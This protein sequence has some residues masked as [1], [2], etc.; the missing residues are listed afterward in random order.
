MGT[1]FN[2]TWQLRNEIFLRD[3]RNLYFKG[4]L[5]WSFFLFYGNI[6]LRSGEMKGDSVGI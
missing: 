1:K 3:K 4:I 6:N 5:E 2:D